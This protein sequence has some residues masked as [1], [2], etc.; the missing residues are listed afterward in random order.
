MRIF[1]YILTRVLGRM[2]LWLPALCLLVM[3]F[4]LADQGRRLAKVLGWP[5][6]LQ[7]A[8]LHLPLA[9]VQVMPVALLLASVL[10]LVALRRRG[11]LLALAT[12]GA[13]P[14]VRCAPLLCAGMLAALGALLLGE[15]MVPITE[16]RADRLYRHRR[17]SSLTGLLPAPPW[18]KLGRWFVQITPRDPNRSKVVALDVH[19]HRVHR[20]LHGQWTDGPPPRFV[21]ADHRFSGEGWTTTPAEGR[22][23]PSFGKPWRCGAPAVAGPR[24]C[25]PRLCGDTFTGC[26]RPA[27]F[28]RAILQ[29]FRQ[30]F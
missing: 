18:V 5:V 29:V 16:Q 4:D 6:V 12:L 17:V 11:E 14:M 13:P 9:A 2:L 27:N 22:R 21:G 20:R 25:P 15:A 28:E 1:V 3:A 7:A 30:R 23:R 26:G 8:A 10:T 24:P 19:G